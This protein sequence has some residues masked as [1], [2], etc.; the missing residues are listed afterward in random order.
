MK[1]IKKTVDLI[2]AE[3]IEHTVSRLGKKIESINIVGSYAIGKYSLQA[4]NVNF[5]IISKANESVNLYLPLSNIFLD[6]AKKFKKDINIFHDLKPYRQTLFVPEKNK[7]TLTINSGLLDMRDIKRNFDVPAY[8]LRGWITTRKVVYGKDVLG[9]LKFEIKKNR[10]LIEQKRFVLLTIKKQ[11]EKV[12]YTYDWRKYPELLLE[13]ALTFG[14]LLLF[15]GVLLKL[16]DKEIKEKLDLE[17][18]INKEKLVNFY[19]RR[20]DKKIGEFAKKI[21]NIRKNYLKWKSNTEKAVELYK[22]DWQLWNLIWKEFQ[23]WVFLK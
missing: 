21:I 4:P 14:K 12:P 20:F 16:N 2:V 15:E 10:M 13:E 3:F 6:L 11:L 1:N 18:I 22:I 5:E 8:V 9:K 7:T 17:L 19:I 23:N